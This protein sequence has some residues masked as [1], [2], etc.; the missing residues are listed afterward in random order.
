M[1]KSD[2]DRFGKKTENPA[3]GNIQISRCSGHAALY[4]SPLRHQ[5]FIALRIETASYRRDLHRRWHHG[6]A[7]IVEVYMSAAQF[8]EA[9]TNMNT[10][11]V[12]CTLVD[13]RD[14]AT[15]ERLRPKLNEPDGDGRSTHE[16]EI[17]ESCKGLVDKAQAA[18]DQLEEALAGKTVKKGDLKELR[19]TLAKLRM[20]VSSNM[21]FIQQSFH[22]ATER[23]VQR[24]KTEIVALADQVVHTR[25]LEALGVKTGAQ[26]VG[27][28][29][30]HLLPQPE[31]RDDQWRCPECKYINTIDDPD[32]CAECGYGE[33]DK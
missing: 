29:N 24:A 31:P 26:L 5:H 12:P 11:G 9:I 16:K 32:S 21:P 8:A 2:E 20:E 6:D 4:D 27:A 1:T 18:I 7:Q 10:S 19:G 15:G 25:G 23:E 14:P 13:Y 28:D 22:E 33:R 17:E 3:F 30:A